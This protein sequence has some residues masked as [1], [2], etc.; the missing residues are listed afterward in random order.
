MWR[1]CQKK[2][3]RRRCFK[4]IQEGK[5]SFE[6]PRKRLLEDVENYKKKMG[7]RCWKKIAK[8]ADAWKLT[9]KEARFLHGR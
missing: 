8:V 3:L 4:S 1:E 7:V 2:E 5:W 9:M 6:K